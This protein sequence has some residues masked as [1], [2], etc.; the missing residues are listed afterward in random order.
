MN[1]RY[2]SGSNGHKIAFTFLCF[3]SIAMG[4]LS[5]AATPQKPKAATA[6]AKAE[7][8]SRITPQIPGANRY[9]KDKVFLENADILTADERISTEFQILKGNVRF[10]RGDMYMF[11]DSAYF[12][13]LSSSLDAFGN[14]RMTQ[15]DTLFV[16]ADVLHYYGEDQIA[17]LRENVRLEN[18]NTTLITDS[19][20]YEISSNVGYY[21]NGG[22]IID[23]KNKTELTSQD[24]RYELDT[25]Q[26]E[27]SSNVLLVNEKY[28]MKTELLRY[29]T[30][31]HIATI[32]D[33]TII[34][35]DSNTV[36]T[37]NGWYNTSADDA[38]LYDRSVVNAKDGKTLVGDTVY[39]N[40]KF[41][42]GEARG[43]V[44]ITDPNNKVILDGDYGYHDDN[45][46]YS[47]VTKRARAREFSQKDTIYMHADTLCTIMTEDSVRILKAFRGVRFFRSDVQGICDSLQLSMADTIVNMYRHAVLWNEDKQVSGN[48]INAHMNDSTMDWATLPNFG[49]LT[50][51]VGETYFDQLSAK[52]IKAYFEKKEMRRMDADGNVQIIMYPMENDSTYNKHVSAEAS[53]LRLDLKEKQKIDKIAMWPEV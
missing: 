37:T 24:G 33:R 11:C 38:T 27:F 20:D 53:Y 25:K 1:K 36:V 15:G 16:Y 14:V 43:N 28:T 30:G 40:R 3:C 46:H 50:Q 13:E 12:Y 44:I 4:V 22:K 39:Y 23:N 35:S 18:R 32:V 21:F 47:Y 2:S 29:N 42:Y 45:T 8:V 49:F 6:G 5:W 7:R 34:E 31:T 26:A 48:E 9:Q 52:K 10:R 19:L 17:Q 51:L 41:N